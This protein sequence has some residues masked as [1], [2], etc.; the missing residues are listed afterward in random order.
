MITVSVGSAPLSALYH[1][2]Y[3]LAYLLL[4][5][6]AKAWLANK[7]ASFSAALGKRQWIRLLW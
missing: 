4:R 3:V 5:V 1:R 6:R 2:Y 7:M